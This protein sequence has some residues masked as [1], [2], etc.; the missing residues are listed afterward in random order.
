MSLL[1]IWS[2]IIEH[3]IYKLSDPRSDSL[4]LILS[5]DDL[6]ALFFEFIFFQIE[7]PLQIKNSIIWTGKLV[8][9]N[10]IV[11]ETK[12]NLFRS[13]VKLLSYINESPSD[14]NYNLSKYFLALKEFVPELIESLKRICNDEQGIDLILQVYFSL[15]KAYKFNLI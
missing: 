9:L 2:E 13:Y 5:N 4:K 1:S 14:L 6:C 11:N 7:T 10:K 15:K 12:V 3:L 8:D